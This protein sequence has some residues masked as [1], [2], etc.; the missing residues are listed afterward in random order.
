MCFREQYVPLKKSSVAAADT[1]IKKQPCAPASDPT[2]LPLEA[3][4]SAPNNLMS[5][6]PNASGSRSASP[7]ASR[8]SMLPNDQHRQKPNKRD[9]SQVETEGRTDAKRAKQQHLP[10]NSPIG[11]PSQQMSCEHNQ[12]QGGMPALNFSCTGLPGSVLPVQSHSTTRIP[13]FAQQL[14]ATPVPQDID[15]FIAKTV[16]EVRQQTNPGMVAQGA[17]H[18]QSSQTG[19]TLA[20]NVQSSQSLT[21]GRITPLH[22]RMYPVATAVPPLAYQAP[23]QDRAMP[24]ISIPVEEYQQSHPQDKWFYRPLTSQPPSVPKE[25][26]K[27]RA[28]L[29]PAVEALNQEAL[30]TIPDAYRNGWDKLLCP[31]GFADACVTAWEEWIPHRR[32]DII[33]SL[34]ATEQK[35]L[36]SRYRSEQLAKR[37][38][39]EVTKPAMNTQSDSSPATL[40]GGDSDCREKQT[41]LDTKSLFVDPRPGLFE[42]DLTQDCPNLDPRLLNQSSCRASQANRIC[43]RHQ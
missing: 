38:N 21:Y 2:L 42:K 20:P 24:K 16:Q 33:L 6:R 22:S 43:I 25:L 36:R 7:A 8:S 39:G 37:Q 18:H 41:S 4:R 3:H 28:P 30:N 10:A 34:L 14:G 13:P 31:M 15:S 27:G 5:A 23:K 32:P 35:G 29:T 11:N 40:V 17:L 9:I 26:L 19:A 12:N 1:L